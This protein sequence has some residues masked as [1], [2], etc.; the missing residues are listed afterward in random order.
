MPT[1]AVVAG[2]SHDPLAELDRMGIP[3]VRQWLRD[4]WGVWSPAHR[5]VVIATGLSPVEERCVLAHE[6]EHILVGDT[7]CGGR[8]GL[9]AERLADL[10]A[11]RKLVALSDFCRVRQW[12]TS[13]AEMAEELGVTTWILRTRGADLEG[14]AQWLGTSKIAG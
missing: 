14:G 10:R 3:I 13:E 11:A 5:A 6:L 2:L 12:A 7:G 1:A 9:R 8:D 4:T